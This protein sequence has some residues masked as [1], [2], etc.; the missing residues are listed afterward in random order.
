MNNFKETPIVKKSVSPPPLKEKVLDSNGF[1]TQPFVR[2]LLGIQRNT[3]SSGVDLSDIIDEINEINIKISIIETRLNNMDVQL[4]NIESDIT[5]LQTEMTT[6]IDDAPSDGNLY[7][8]QDGQWV[9][10]I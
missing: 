4:T 6:K 1:L 5:D 2:Y 10:I 3:E 7:G 8:R 9:E